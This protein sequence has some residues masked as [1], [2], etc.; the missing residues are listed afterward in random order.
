MEEIWKDIEGYGGLYQI[1]NQGKV[2][3]FRRTTGKPY[4]ILKQ[5]ITIWGYKYVN[6]FNQG[7]KMKTIHRLVALAFIPNPENKREVNHKDSNRLNNHVDNLEWVTSKENTRHAMDND[8]MD[9]TKACYGEKHGRSK[10]TE[11]DVR[12]IKI[13]LRDKTKTQVQLAREYNVHTSNIHFIKTNVNWKH[14]AV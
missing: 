4:R 8:R 11:D 14:I 6:L 13:H 10:L 7:G 2:K 12:S 1:S 9:W 3:S 5:G